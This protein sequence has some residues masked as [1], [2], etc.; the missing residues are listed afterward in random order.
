MISSFRRD[1]SAIVRPSVGRIWPVNARDDL[2]T[3]ID[4]NTA[5]PAWRLDVWQ[6]HGRPYHRFA[7]CNHQAGREQPAVALP[8]FGI[9]QT[10]CIGLHCLVGIDPQITAIRAGEATIRSILSKLVHI[11]VER[12]ETSIPSW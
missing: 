12:I 9:T 6:A 5:P 3:W 2:A 7:A 11:K 1:R 8:E 4:A 10:K